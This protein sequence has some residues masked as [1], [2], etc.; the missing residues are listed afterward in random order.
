MA[1]GN[2]RFV[3]YGHTPITPSDSEELDKNIVA[4]IV[5]D[6]GDV[7]MTDRHGTTHVYTSVPAYTTFEQFVPL[8]INATGTAATNIVGWFA[9]PPILGQ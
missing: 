4:I 6:G 2:D 5:I 1:G 3:A 7:S 9:R 8:R